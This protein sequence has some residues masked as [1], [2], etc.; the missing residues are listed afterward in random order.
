MNEKAGTLQRK[1]HWCVPRKGIAWPQSQFPHSRVCEQFIY[2][3]DRS[4][5]FSA[6]YFS[7]SIFNVSNICPRTCVGGRCVP[8]LDVRPSDDTSLNYMSQQQ[9]INYAYEFQY[10]TARRC[11]VTARAERAKHHGLCTGIS[12][13]RDT[14]FRD[15]LCKER[16]KHPETNIRG[17][18]GRGHRECRRYWVESPWASDK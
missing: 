12:R 3:Q 17:H 14:S 5:Y 1:S 2:S 18:V 16:K 11:S 7:D 4:T 10:N 15:V 8:S 13:C 6:A 9:R